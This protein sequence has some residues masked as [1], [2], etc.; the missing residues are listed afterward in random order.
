M[1]A[2]V[3]TAHSQLDRLDGAIEGWKGGQGPV[4]FGSAGYLFS[5]K[6]CRDGTGRPWGEAGVGIVPE[7]KEAG[8][9]CHEASA[10]GQPRDDGQGRPARGEPPHPVG[11][12]YA[13][14]PDILRVNHRCGISVLHRIA[15]VRSD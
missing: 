7:R 4:V 11:H 6:K 5:P 9:V 2:R 13:C 3:S 1:Y 14:M 15:E 12:L 10:Q 8:H